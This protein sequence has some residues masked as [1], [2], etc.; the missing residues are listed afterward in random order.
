MLSDTLATLSLGFYRYDDPQARQPVYDHNGVALGDRLVLGRVRVTAEPFAPDSIMA[1]PLAR[2]QGEIQLLSADID[3]DAAGT[4]QRIQLQWQ[5]TNAVQTDYTVFVQLVSGDGQVIAQLDQPPQA[6]RAPT[7]TWRKGE[8]FG[9][10]YQLPPPTK[11]W[12][13]LILG[14]YDAS[15]KRLGL[16]VPTPGQDF[17]ILLENK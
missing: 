11:P 7:S 13:R 1:D 15:G 14:L 2:W 8:T 16:T 17:L 12:A 5:A 10:S 3:R 4:P 6:G 9:D